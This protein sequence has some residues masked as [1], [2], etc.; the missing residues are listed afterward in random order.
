MW[1]SANAKITFLLCLLMVLVNTAYGQVMAK[2]DHLQ[3]PTVKLVVPYSPGSGPDSLARALAD[4]LSKNIGTAVIVENISGASGN[5]G[6]IKVANAPKESLEI[7]VTANAIGIN[8]IESPKIAVNPLKDLIPIS[9]VAK[10]N[11]VLVINPSTNLSS[12]PDLIE[13]S[14]TQS[15]MITFA[16]PG[17]GTPHYLAIRQFEN[18]SNIHLLHVP[19]KNTSQALTALIGG[20]VNAMFLP[21][22]LALPLIKDGRISPLAIISNKRSILSPSIPT[23][24]E[25]QL[26]TVNSDIWYGLF[27]NKSMSS[28][29]LNLLEQAISTSLK[30]TEFIQ[31]LPQGLE[32]IK[33]SKALLIEKLHADAVYYKKIRADGP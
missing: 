2:S 7:L 11:L 3:L 8:F 31:A 14:K 27:T 24:A 9:L 17:I 23:F 16:S 18:A 1:C 4:P 15:P 19:Y 25:Y 10:T 21:L 5:I 12:L 28:H 13:K 32:P 29:R 20:E 30:S 26:G 33:P 22:Q 6:A